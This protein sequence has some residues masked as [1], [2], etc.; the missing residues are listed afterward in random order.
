MGNNTSVNLG[1]PSSSTLSTTS[2]TTTGNDSATSSSSSSSTVDNDPSVVTT[3]S[4]D[5]F[6][7]YQV[8][9][10]KRKKEVSIDDQNDS[11]LDEDDGDLIER[12]L[13][14]SLECRV[15][16]KNWDLGYTLATPNNTRR[17]L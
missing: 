2:T 7:D 17:T 11:S 6:R 9:F 3:L 5:S 12:P 16:W 15:Q 10:T 14:Y 4:A 8:F 13:D 1:S